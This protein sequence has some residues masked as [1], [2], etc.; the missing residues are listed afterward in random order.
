M[1]EEGVNFIPHREILTYE[2]MHHIVGLCVQNG[3]RK[4]RITGGEP[5]V[6][7]GIVNF[8][9]K[10]GRIEGLE[11]IALTTNGVFLKKFARDLRDCGICSINVSIDT[12]NPDRFFHTTKRDLFYHVWDGIEEAE[13]LWGN[14]IKLNVVALKGVNDDEI[15]DF[16]RLT[17][18]RPFQ[19]RFIE[20]MPVG[21]ENSLA[22]TSFLPV[23]EIFTI[24]ES[25]GKITSVNPDPLGGPA[26]RYKLDGAKGEIGFIGALS[27]HFCDKCNRLRLTPDGGLRGCLFSDNE[28]DIKTPLR[29]KKG[30]DHLLS[31]I[32]DT[33]LNKPKNSGLGEYRPR[34][35]VRPMNS[36]GG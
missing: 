7:K 11:Q 26:K 36:I 3:I 35:C 9:E 5:L 22:S 23:N 31:L 32:R 21:K 17:Y 2:E 19:I 6:R 27:D 1:P 12:L 30:D 18:G 28:I 25:L 14:P 4:V 8:I 24:V 15:L 34:K 29:Q 16:A 10:L 20:F 13:S 33:I